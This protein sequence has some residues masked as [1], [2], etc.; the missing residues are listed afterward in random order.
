MTDVSR[1]TSPNLDKVLEGLRKVKDQLV[2]SQMVH[3][4]QG[5]IEGI[6][7][8]LEGLMAARKACEPDKENRPELIP[9][10][11]VAIVTL[12]LAAEMAEIEVAAEGK[13]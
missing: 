12:N 2:D 13:R 9:G 1:E 10:L 11:E 8:S 4:K 3:Y 7:A 5:V 6:R